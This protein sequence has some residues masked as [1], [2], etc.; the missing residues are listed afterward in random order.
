[1]MQQIKLLR[2][3][4]KDARGGRKKLSDLGMVQSMNRPGRMNDNAHMESFFHSMKCEELY[5]MKFEIGAASARHA[6]KLRPVLQRS[7]AAFIA[8][9]LAASGL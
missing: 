3:P 2:T 5:G 9:I 4:M 6:K 1:M 7:T 8:A